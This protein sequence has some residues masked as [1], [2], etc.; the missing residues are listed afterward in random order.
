MFTIYVHVLFG[1]FFAFLVLSPNKQMDFMQYSFVN[2]MIDSESTSDVL[3]LMI[4]SEMAPYNAQLKDKGIEVPS[5]SSLFFQT[6]AGVKLS[7]FSSLLETAIPG[8]QQSASLMDSNVASMPIESP[9]PDFDKLLEEGGQDEED[10]PIEKNEEANV[11]VYH[12]HSWEAFLPM[13]DSK[14]KPS[15]ASSTDRDKNIV[16]VG[17]ML[18]E[19][20]E[21]RGI[22]TMHDKTN[23]AA[24]LNEQGLNHND[25][26]TFARKTIKAAASESDDI[27]YF[28]DIH[29]DAQRKDITTSQINGKP[30]A[31]IYFVVGTAH[32]QYKKNAAFA[33]QINQ[34]LEDKYPGISRG[35]YKKDKTMGNGVYNQDFSENAILIEVGGIDN[36]KEELR[37]SSKALAEVL[38]N[39][40]HQAEKVNAK[41]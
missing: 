34:S 32:E 4:G 39:H 10:E 28:I 2:E 24:A 14:T 37:N 9:P 3:R 7:D 1:V 38:S 22:Q 17:S 5:V 35:V 18:T 11:F 8:L 21:E 16:M 13:L 25:S 6:A 19:E 20:L 23:V 30:Y 36:T 29:R 15:E 12:S 41:Q 26:Y 31:K 40:I 33:N 27:S